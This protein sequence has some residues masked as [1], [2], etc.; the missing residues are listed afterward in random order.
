MGKFELIFSPF[1]D[2]NIG[3]VR[4]ALRPLHNEISNLFLHFSPVH[5]YTGYLANQPNTLLVSQS[6]VYIGDTQ[7]HRATY[8]SIAVLHQ[9]RLY[10][11][12]L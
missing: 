4:E 3:I 11:L 10:I 2:L 9:L 5:T 1:I 8:L 6:V 7:R 12:Y